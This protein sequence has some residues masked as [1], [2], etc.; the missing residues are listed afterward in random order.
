MSAV[1]LS[2]LTIVSEECAKSKPNEPDEILDRIRN[3]S[4]MLLALFFVSLAAML[5]CLLYMQA[6]LA[7][8]TSNVAVT[9]VL[10]ASIIGLIP[11]SLY[12][13]DKAADKIQSTSIFTTAA[14]LA[15]IMQQQQEPTL[16]TGPPPSSLPTSEPPSQPQALQVCPSTPSSSTSLEVAT[17]ADSMQQEPTPSTAPPSP[18]LPITS[19]LPSPPQALQVCSFTP[20]SSTSMEAAALADNM[21]REPTPS[22]GPALPASQHTEAPIEEDHN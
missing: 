21:Q 16:S 15:G 6:L 8:A 20:S 3:S 4:V 13:A 7:G 17:L 1:I 5:L 11:S 2:P 10:F 12:G 22:T 19:E 9:I 14:A 18:S